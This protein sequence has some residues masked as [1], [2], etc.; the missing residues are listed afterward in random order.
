MTVEPIR[1]TPNTL[2]LLDQRLLP[3]DVV[4][5]ECKDS[6]SVAVAI[7][8]M[9]VR[10]APA[11]GVA[12]AF[13]MALAT[14]V[15][16][17]AAELRAARPNAVNLMWAVDRMLA[18]HARGADLVAEAETMFDEDVEANRRIGRNGAV[19]LGNQATVLTHCNAGA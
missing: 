17:A 14:D 7:K 18:A 2:H 3:R 4:W 1:W 9:I 11:I 15:D 13:G 12:A 5:V 6:H 16:A 8:E 10:G 19:L